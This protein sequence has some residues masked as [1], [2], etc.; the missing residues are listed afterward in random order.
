MREKLEVKQ[1][2]SQTDFLS[3]QLMG[4]TL[5]TRTRTGLEMVTRSIKPRDLNTP[6]P[7]CSSSW[8]CIP[9]Q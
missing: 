5:R 2:L 4:R 9:G 3:R 7:W 6:L 1:P 8:D